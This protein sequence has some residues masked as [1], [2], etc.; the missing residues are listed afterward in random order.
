M[1]W[2]LFCLQ[3]AAYHPAQP[4]GTKGVQCLYLLIAIAGIGFS[5]LAIVSPRTAWYLR[6]GWKYKDVEPSNAALLLTQVG[7]FFGVLFLL[8]FIIIIFTIGLEP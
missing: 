1:C 7:G 8:A 6:D 3:R 5:L 2:Y 4:A